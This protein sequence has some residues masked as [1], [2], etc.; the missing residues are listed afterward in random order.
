MNDFIHNVY[1][2]LDVKVNFDYVLQNKGH[3]FKWMNTGP[4]FEK[5]L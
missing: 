1:S 5:H 2:L 4:F 3:S